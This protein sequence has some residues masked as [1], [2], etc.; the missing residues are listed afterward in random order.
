MEAPAQLDTVPP[1]AASAHHSRRG[2]AVESA[3]GDLQ[4]AFT[5]KYVQ[6]Q[7]LSLPDR[8]SVSRLCPSKGNPPC[9]KS[10][11]SDLSLINASS[12]HGC[13]SPS[14]LNPGRSTLSTMEA[15]DPPSS[16]APSASV[17]TDYLPISTRS[18]HPSRP[19][20]ES[21]AG[22]G[23]FQ[24][25]NQDQP[26][27]NVLLYYQN[28]G[29]INSSVAEYQ[30][31]LSDGCY[32]AYAFTETWLKDCTTSKQLFDD[33]FSV[34]RQD[35]SSI[36]SN[37]STGGGVLLAVRSRFKSRLVNP[38]NSSIEQLWVAISTEDATIYV[39]VIYI[40]PDRINDSSVIE[41]HV[42]SLNWVVSQMGPRDNFAILGDFNL[43]SIAWQCSS[44]G[45]Y[46]PCI[47]RSSMGQPSR[48]L[49]DAYSTAGLRQMVGVE[50]ENNR[51]LDLCFVSEELGVNC[52]VMQAP[53]PLVKQVRHHPPLLLN[54]KMNPCRSFQDTSESVSYD[55][56]RANFAEMNDFLSQLDWSEILS[57]SDP[58]LAASTLS[59]VLLYAIDQ[60]VP[61]M[62]YRKPAKP[63]W[64]NA[65]L[66]N[67]KREKQAAL[68]RHSKYRTDSTKAS[69]LE[70][71]SAY[72]HLNNCLYNAHL[73]RLQSRLKTNPKSFWRHVNDQR[74]ESGLPSTMNDGLREADTTTD[75]ADMFRSQ[76]SSVFVNEQ[77]DPQDVTNATQN[78]PS[79]PASGLQIAVTN[80]AIIDAC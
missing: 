71:N 29:G 68:R 37:K 23:V 55:F 11:S 74:K 13:S 21:S 24:A 56:S 45:F 49:L 78:V 53:A 27:T 52:S 26:A 9:L 33:S 16:V 30:L 43:S 42:D 69:Y 66:K 79:F 19:G 12:S 50:N 46:F 51:S 15:P 20:P 76:F 80:D 38:P 57:D 75:I 47:S 70:V 64:S 5:G 44:F 40:P 7:T 54:L 67:L 4:P 31:A 28:V 77:L 39:C 10:S 3:V 63:V 6:Y 35:R 1:F 61:A 25:T 59:G 17:T 36:N 14:P 58:N 41:T 22:D 62:P 2:P 18:D 34:Y 73:S 65:T 48:D 72:K 60:F 32:D 8:N